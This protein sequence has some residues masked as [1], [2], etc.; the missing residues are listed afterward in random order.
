MQNMYFTMQSIYFASLNTY[1][2]SLN[3]LF[4]VLFQVFLLWGISYDQYLAYISHSKYGEHAIIRMQLREPSFLAQGERESSRPHRGELLITVGRSE[5]RWSGSEIGVSEVPRPLILTA[6]NV[7]SGGERQPLMSHK[8]RRVAQRPHSKSYETS[9]PEL[10]LQFLGR[11]ILTPILASALES[12]QTF[13][14]SIL[15]LKFKGNNSRIFHKKRAYL[16]LFHHVTP[17]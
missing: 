13:S 1:F 7:P 16:P 8:P 14:K 11:L 9:S 2:A 6:S 12:K 17:A 10:S 4:L 5:T 3:R 15:F